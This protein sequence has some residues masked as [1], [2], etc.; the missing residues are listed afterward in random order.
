MQTLEPPV[1][2]SRLRARLDHPLGMWMVRSISL[3]GVTLILVSVTGWWLTTRVT[4]DEGF[5]DVVTA[6]LPRESV[7][8]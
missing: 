7:R 1:P 5:A 3:L 2:G 8:D 4:S 6:T